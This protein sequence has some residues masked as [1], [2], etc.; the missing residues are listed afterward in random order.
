MLLDEEKSDLKGLNDSAKH[1]EESKKTRASTKGAKPKK[2][3]AKN[4]SDSDEDEEDFDLDGSDIEE[5][6]VEKPKKSRKVL[7]S[8]NGG[9]V[10]EEAKRQSGRRA[11]SKPVTVSLSLIIVKVCC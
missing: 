10:K 7:K 2:R 11:R 3:K 6:I 1:G 5:S 8:N 9:D 4:D